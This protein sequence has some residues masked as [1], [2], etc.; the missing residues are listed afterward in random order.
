M[1]SRAEVGVE[2]PI[3]E[4]FVRAIAARDRTGL[5]DLL[6]PQIDFRAMTPG[7][8]WEAS[9]AVEVVDEVILG[10]W[11]EPTDRIE[12][13]ES[14]EHDVVVD[15]ERVGYRFRVSNADGEYAV[16]QQAYLGA[17]NDVIAWLRIMCA[18]YQSVR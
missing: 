6:A 14:I 15:R 18:G 16:E 4:R 11:F 5:L 9:S 2:M 17:Q 7:R 1:S 3:G 12:A 13:I 10:H 8:F